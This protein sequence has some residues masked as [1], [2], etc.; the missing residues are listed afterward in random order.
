MAILDNSTREL[1]NLKDKIE[2]LVEFFQTMLKEI[3]ENVDGSLRDF[4]RPIENGITEGN[5]PEEVEAIRV[6]R[7]SKQVSQPI[8]S[9]LT[10]S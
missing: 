2:P 7:K 5:T 1:G 6:S 9:R 10:Y 3:Q 8:G 4:L